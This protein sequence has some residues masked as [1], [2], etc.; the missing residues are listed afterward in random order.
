MFFHGAGF[1][2]GEGSV[3]FVFGFGLEAGVFLGDFSGVG[4]DFAVGDFEEVVELGDPVFHVHGAAAA[5]LELGEV[6]VDTYDAVQGVELLGGEV[7]LGDGDV[8]F[9][10][11]VSGP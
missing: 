6:Q 7:V 8:A 4:M 11:A 5:G 9:A 2:G 1:G 3:F 10:G